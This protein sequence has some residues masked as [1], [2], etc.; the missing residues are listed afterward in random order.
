MNPFNLGSYETAELWSFGF[1]N[2]GEKIAIAK[3]CTIIDLANI[4]L[5]D[6]AR[7]NAL[8]T[9]VAAMGKLRISNRVHIGGGCH[10]C[11]AADLTFGDIFGT[12]RGVK[13]LHRHHDYSG[14]AMA[15]PCV[16]AEYTRS[17][18]AG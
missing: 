6:D 4:S 17:K 5:G 3:N 11:C 18:R 12:S 7:I 8:T 13:N 16:P 10:F 2:V 1:A 9:I 14:R 15:G